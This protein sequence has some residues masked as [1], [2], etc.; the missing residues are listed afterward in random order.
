MG[1]EQATSRDLAGRA[2]G[3][4]IALALADDDPDGPIRWKAVGALHIRGDAETFAEAAGLC[5]SESRAERVIGVDV[6]GE[7][8]GPQRPFLDE[9]LP[10]LRRLAANES[11]VRVLHAVLI[12]FG[13]LRDPGALPSVIE[14]AGHGDPTVRYGAA[15]ALSHV[16]GRPPDPA[17]LAALRRLAR[18]PDDDVAD[19]AALGLIL[20]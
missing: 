9:T 16:I 18:D 17:G 3:E 5:A 4:L 19:W 10:I 6:L 8:G 13:H 1:T 14:L 2:V 20:P 7:L 11:D 15:Y 12:A